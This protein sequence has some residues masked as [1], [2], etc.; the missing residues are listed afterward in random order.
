MGFDCR[1]AKASRVFVQDNVEAAD[2]VLS[3][4]VTGRATGRSWSWRQRW[5]EQAVYCLL[6]YYSLVVLEG[7]LHL[8]DRVGHEPH[9]GN[10]SP[11]ICR[12]SIHAA[13]AAV[14]AALAVAA[15]ATDIAAAATAA[16]AAVGSNSCCCSSNSCCCSSSSS[17]S[18]S[19]N[20]GCSSRDRDRSTRSSSSRNRGSC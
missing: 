11:A 4:A 20:G 10:S 1:P 8:S 3:L 9:C 14:A 2:M 19:S 5:K 7:S 6:A 15:A 16:T 13:A 17:S 18:S 12:T